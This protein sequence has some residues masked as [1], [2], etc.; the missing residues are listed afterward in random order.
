MIL[1]AVGIFIGVFIGFV[2]AAMFGISK[3]E[4]ESCPCKGKNTS[5]SYQ[6]QDFSSN[7]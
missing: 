1:L 4:G 5:P 3:I 2:L 6:S 7:N